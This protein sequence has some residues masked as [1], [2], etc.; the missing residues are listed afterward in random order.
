[1][2]DPQTPDTVQVTEMT[3]VRDHAFL[4]P[5][6]GLVFLIPPVAGIFQ[7]DI[8]VAGVPFTALY[9]FSLWALL[10]I[11]A[12]RLSHKLRTET[13]PENSDTRA[14]HKNN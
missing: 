14:E 5:A 8:R 4:L 6:I 1:M 11:G 10:I 2:T 3:K 9:L 13:H 7:L 12:A